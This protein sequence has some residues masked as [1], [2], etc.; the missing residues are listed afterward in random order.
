[1]TVLYRYGFMAWFWRLLILLGVGGGG[2][3]LWFGLRAGHIALIAMGLVL[4]TPS[5]FFGLVVAVRI[6]LPVPDTVR[7]V[8]L[9]F[10]RR[11]L[12]RDSL[13]APRVR[14]WYHAEYGRMYAPRVWVRVP[15][16]LPVYIDLLGSIPDRRT[17][18]SIFHLPGS[19]VPNPK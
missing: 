12:V 6:D 7:V 9:L 11:H 1:M 13:H 10:W 14:E 2:L 4:L 18:L 15:N 16:S 5:L 19:A 3:A 8:T 17:F